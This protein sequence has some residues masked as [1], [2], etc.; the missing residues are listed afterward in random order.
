GVHVDQ[1]GQVALG[2]DGPVALD[3]EDRGG[4]LRIDLPAG[5]RSGWV[6]QRLLPPRA[7]QVP[8]VDAPV[9]A[10]REQAAPVDAVADLD[11]TPRRTGEDLDRP[12]RAG[13]PDDR[14]AV[15]AGGGERRS[16]D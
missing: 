16:V 10:G 6:E 7:G 1:V 8:Q 9:L 5:E 15:V 14:R 4:V 11:L 13:V 2:D 3:V 12:Q